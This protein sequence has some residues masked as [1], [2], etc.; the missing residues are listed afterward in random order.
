MFTPVGGAEPDFDVVVQGN[1]TVSGQEI[2]MPTGDLVMTAGTIRGNDAVLTGPLSCTNLTATGP[3]TGTAATFTGE[4]QC[5]S[6]I[7][8][9]GLQIT[10]LA[11]EVAQVFSTITA[12]GIVTAGGLVAG[13]STI[14]G[15]LIVEGNLSVG[16]GLPIP[17]A[18]CGVT[19][20][21]PIGG[22]G[23]CGVV[24]YPAIT[25]QSIV[26]ITLQT[27]QTQI[28]NGVTFSV[29]LLPG[30]GFQIRSSA[31]FGGGAGM[32]WLI[33]RL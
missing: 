8:D 11:C 13:N 21:S 15:N 31:G 6:L 29:S 7:A 14:T 5:D 18:I 26:L 1:L 10:E 2:L 30:V 23:I 32:F 25:A 20:I 12:G 19:S 28:W 3:L 27:D 24:A 17:E 33:A 9:G 16:S 4:L 22:A